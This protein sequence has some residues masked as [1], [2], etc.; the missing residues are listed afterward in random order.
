MDGVAVEIVQNK[1]VVVAACGWNNKTASL[2]QFD[3]AG[4]GAAV[5]VYHVGALA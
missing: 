3:V 1:N 4:D 2:I 5:G